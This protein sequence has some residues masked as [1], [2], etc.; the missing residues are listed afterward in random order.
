MKF[1]VLMSVYNKE[2]PEWLI[3][4]LDSV[5]N[6]TIVPSEVI[7]I[8]D[9]PLTIELNRVI[10]NFCR[11]YPTVFKTYRI[12]KN[13]GLGK[14]LNYGLSKCSNDL[15]ARMDTDDIAKSNRFELQ[16]EKFEKNNDLVICGGQIE[17]FDDNVDNITGIR[18]VPL[19]HKDIISFSK[20]RNPFNHMTVMFKK[21]VIESVGGYQ[22][23]MYFEDYWLWVRVLSKGF[24][25]C[26]VDKVLVSMRA[27]KKMFDRRGGV[28]YLKSIY[29]FEKNLYR[30]KYISIE[31]FIFAVI[32]R[33]VIALV[34]NSIRERIYM[35]GLRKK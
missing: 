29:C 27:G 20:S 6:Q 8:Q 10:D 31:N 33:G 25:C 34:P 7:L 15:V 14:A 16:L 3:I 2:N 5:F 30:F 11:K 28:L 17:E 4:A 24:E 23:M 21:S 1:S 22:H 19:K 32:I 18:A 26:N 12:D 13:V 9:G 35:Y